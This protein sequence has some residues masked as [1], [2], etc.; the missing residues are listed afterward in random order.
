MLCNSK[1]KGVNLQRSLGDTPVTK[2][3]KM[4]SPAEGEIKLVHHLMGCTRWHRPGIA[5]A[6][7]LLPMHQ[8]WGN[9]RHATLE[10]H[11]PQELACHP[12]KCWGLKVKER[13]SV[14]AHTY[15]PS[16]L[17]GWDWEDCSLKP[18]WANQL[19]DSISTNSWGSGIQLSSAMQKDHKHK[20]KTL[21][22]TTW[23][24]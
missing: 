16:D 4:T 12:Q 8:P 17:G 19:Q 11:C 7:F 15:N 22:K 2:V 20:C 5:S 9:S 6:E 10:G 23:S 24:T 13:L 1:E 18:V 14:V 21:F 3:I